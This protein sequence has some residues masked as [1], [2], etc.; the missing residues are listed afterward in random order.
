MRHIPS[1]LHQHVAT[2]GRRVTG[3]CFIAGPLNNQ[4]PGELGAYKEEIKPADARMTEPVH[5][6]QEQPE[7]CRIRP[8]YLVRL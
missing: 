6:N 7:L 2:L 1:T 5:V 4:S 8:D 3:L